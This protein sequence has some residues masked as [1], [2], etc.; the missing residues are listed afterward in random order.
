MRAGLP[1]LTAGVGP[2]CVL[3][4]LAALDYLTQGPAPFAGVVTGMGLFGLLFAVAWWAG[5]CT[6][7]L[8]SA[9]QS[10]LRSVAESAVGVVLVFLLVVP[11][12][13]LLPQPWVM[14]LMQEDRATDLLVMLILGVTL[15]VAGRAMLGASRQ[16][17]V[18]ARAERDTAC[19]RAELAEREQAFARAELQALRAQVEPHFLWNTLANVEYLI[20]KDPPRAQAMMTHL[21][22]YL[23]SSLPSGRSGD[24]TVGSE[25]A[26]VR[27]YAGL[28]QFRM[29]ERLQVELALEPACAGI[30]F[31]PLILQTLI[32]NAIQHGLEPLPGAAHL[33][34]SAR[35]SDT[36][37]GRLVIEV[38]DNGIGLQASP[39]TRGTG[40]GLRNVRERLQA[41]HGKEA[42]LTIT[43]VESGGV[44]ARIEWPLCEPGLPMRAVA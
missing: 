36:E 41:M 3:G 18:A 2:L 32:E 13:L 22:D 16:A 38:T 17:A 39:R 44:C 43:G 42:S 40:L 37:P 35:R 10:A 5:L 24:T 4:A 25:F 8:Y 12:T 27:A 6:G 21:I 30:S 23:R 14:T 29:G 26:S 20:R 1:K 9:V 31:P 11:L 7:P 28:M 34:V 33:R 19:V 15:L